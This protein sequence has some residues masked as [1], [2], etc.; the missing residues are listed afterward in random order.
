MGGKSQLSLQ[1]AGDKQ[2]YK[3]TTKKVSEDEKVEGMLPEDAGEGGCDLGPRKRILKAHRKSWLDVGRNGRLDQ[4]EEGQSITG[5][6]SQQH[7]D[8]RLSLA[9]DQGQSLLEA[10]MN[11]VAPRAVGRIACSQ[12]LLSS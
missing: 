12:Y 8:R 10:G 7:M 6:I 2:F 1:E 4:G 9:S 5:M 3:V 11:Q